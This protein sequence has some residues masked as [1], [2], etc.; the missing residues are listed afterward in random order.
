MRVLMDPAK[1]FSLGAAG[2]YGWDGWTGPYMSVCPAEDMV[3]LTFQQ[4]TDSGTTPLTRKI[5]NIVY[6]RIGA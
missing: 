6:A 3:L 2:E 5:R 1:S 4:R